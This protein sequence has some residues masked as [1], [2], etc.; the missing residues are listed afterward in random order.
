MN[1]L[2]KQLSS[3]G[4]LTVDLYSFVFCILIS[5]LVAWITSLMY[6]FFYENRATGSQIH[7]AFALISPSVTMLFICVQL[8]L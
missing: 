6:L 3:E 4:T 7:R 5:I 2:L 8:P 1:N